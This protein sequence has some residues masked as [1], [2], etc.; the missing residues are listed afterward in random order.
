MKYGT[1][2]HRINQGW[3]SEQAISKPVESRERIYVKPSKSIEAFGE[4]KTAAEW[5][6]DARV[7]VAP[8][9]FMRRLQ[10]GWSSE[11]AMSTPLAHAN[12]GGERGSVLHRAFGEEKTLREWARDERCRV[13]EMTL[14]KNLQAGMSLEDALQ[15]RRKPGRHFVGTHEDFSN[16]LAELPEVMELLWDGA[17]IWV[18]E[19]LDLRRISLIHKEV[20][21]TLA[22]DLFQDLVAGN[23]LAKRFETDTICHFEWLRPE[24]DAPQMP[25]AS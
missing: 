6:A 15:F 23:H 24:V 22:P 3:D 18:Y 20:R 14:R 4:L 5:A 16:H 10:H 19:S 13:S 12:N 2:A 9:V 8:T 25:E 17:E 21:H 11:S 7:I 1:L